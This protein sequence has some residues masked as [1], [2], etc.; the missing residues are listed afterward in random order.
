MTASLNHAAAIRR[1]E[2]LFNETKIEPK[3][4]ADIHI[5]VD[6]KQNKNCNVHGKN[7]RGSLGNILHA[8]NHHRNSMGNLSHNRKDHHEE[9]LNKGIERRRGSMPALNSPS[10]YGYHR[11]GSL[12]LPHNPPKKNM[13]HPSQFSSFLREDDL[14]GYPPKNA[15]NFKPFGSKRDLVGG[16]MSSLDNRPCVHVATPIR[17]SSKNYSTDSLDGGGGRRNS[18]NPERRWSSGRSCGW[19]DKYRIDDVKVSIGVLVA[20]YYCDGMGVFLTGARIF[21]MYYRT[22]IRPHTQDVSKMVYNSGIENGPV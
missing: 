5:E 11:R 13:E 14:G 20:E 17:R 18:W 8:T 10:H 4:S 15:P 2:A 19:E 9:Y 3:P 7:E 21:R 1:L 12:A 6:S 22:S 16:S